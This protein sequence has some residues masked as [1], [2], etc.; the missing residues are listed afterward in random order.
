MTRREKKLLRW[1]QA[2]L[3]NKEIGVKL[4]VNECAVK[5]LMKK[6]FRKMKVRRRTD[7]QK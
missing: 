5:Y 2:G 4:D 7:L 6:L 3:T 1:I